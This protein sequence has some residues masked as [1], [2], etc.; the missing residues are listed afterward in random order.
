[1]AQRSQI[2]AF[3][4][5][6]TRSRFERYVK[7]HGMKKAAVVERA[8]LHHLQAL[9]ELPADVVIPPRLM[10]SQATFAR[11]V[12]RLKEPG[13]PTEAMEALFGLPP[14]EASCAT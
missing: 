10:V 8:L 4:S 5:D 12:E 7:A 9:E 13:E 3:V 6:D 1:M 14:G 2:S 11:I